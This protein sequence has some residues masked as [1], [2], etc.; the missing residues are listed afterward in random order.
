MVELQIVVRNGSTVKGYRYRCTC[1]NFCLT[2]FQLNCQRS[3]IGSNNGDRSILYGQV[4]ASPTGIERDAIDVCKQLC[5]RISGLAVCIGIPTGKG[6]G[7]VTRFGRCA[8]RRN[9]CAVVNFFRLALVTIYESHVN[10]GNN[11]FVR[12][13]SSAQFRL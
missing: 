10:G 5:I 4:S 13:A 3:T 1:R 6:G 8:K 12:Y 11:A 2:V 7:G 9:F